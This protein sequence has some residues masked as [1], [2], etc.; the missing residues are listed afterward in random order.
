[1]CVPAAFNV[2]NPVFLAV[3]VGIILDGRITLLVIDPPADACPVLTAAV[4]DG[5]IVLAKAMIRTFGHV[6]WYWNG[7]A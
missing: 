3:I 2:L 7:F 6:C 5:S 4:A 1:M